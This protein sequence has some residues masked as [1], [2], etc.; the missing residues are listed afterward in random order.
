MDFLIRHPVFAL[1]SPRNA[2]ATRK[3]M[4]EYALE[5][6]V[7]E[8][9]GCRSSKRFKPQVHHIERVEDAPLKAA[10]KRNF[11][12]LCPDHHF[13]VGHGCSYHQA[14]SN[15]RELCNAVEIDSNDNGEVAQLVEQVA[16]RGF[17]SPTLA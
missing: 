17:P 11:I 2:W 6:G 16:L 13:S 14:V 5:V 7:C 9:K 1:A 8:F 10:D 12:A 15:V 4:K 3:A